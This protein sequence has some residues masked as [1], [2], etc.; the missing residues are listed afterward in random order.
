MLSKSIS[1]DT[2][3]RPP[4]DKLRALPVANKPVSKEITKKVDASSNNGFTIITNKRHQWRVRPTVVG[5][6]NDVEFRGSRLRVDLFVSH[7]SSEYYMKHVCKLITGIGIEVLGLVK[8]SH[9]DALAAF[10]KL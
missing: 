1:I 9:V 6:K 7:I 4:Q 3:C 8:V 2:C 10:F 5:T